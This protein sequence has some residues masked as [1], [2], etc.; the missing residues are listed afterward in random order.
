[1]TNRPSSL[2]VR[3]LAGAVVLLA[4]AA[5]LHAQSAGQPETRNGVGPADTVGSEPSERSEMYTAEVAILRD[6]ATGALRKPTD[7][8]TA[9][10]VATLKKLTKRSPLVPTTNAD[11]TITI[12]FNGEYD[13]VV[14]ARAKE[15]GTYETLCVSSLEEGVSFLGLKRV[16]TPKPGT[17]ES[18]MGE[19]WR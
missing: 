2:A 15:D 9:E 14:L 6:A 3:I 18:G 16:E 1:M 19:D 12:E 8:E 17:G 4:A 5:T 10:L 11:G 13:N 7:A